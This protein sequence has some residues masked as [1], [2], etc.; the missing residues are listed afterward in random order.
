MVEL[1]VAGAV[2][3]PLTTQLLHAEPN[4]LSSLDLSS[5]S[6]DCRADLS[7]SPDCITDCSTRQE[8]SDTLVSTNEGAAAAAAAGARAAR[9]GNICDALEH[10]HKLV[11]RQ[12]IEDTQVQIQS[13][14]EQI[15]KL[16]V[17]RFSHAPQDTHVAATAAL[18]VQNR[19]L[20]KETE[21][22]EGLGSP[23]PPVLQQSTSTRG[24]RS[25]CN[26]SGEGAVNITASTARGHNKMT[27][28]ST[29]IREKACKFDQSLVASAAGVAGLVGAPIGGIDGLRGVQTAVY[30]R[31]AHAYNSPTSA[32]SEA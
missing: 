31:T 16:Q 18:T 25:V 21:I 3:T 6:E 5:S 19:P 1:N 17:L 28:M 24:D 32:R 7:S 15:E 29:T 22:Q 30:T 27:R 4:V 9:R 23:M 12:K 14:A 20:G 10:E 26:R 11:V 2:A 13:L 8:E